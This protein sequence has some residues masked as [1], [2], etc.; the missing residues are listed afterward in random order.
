MDRFV[1]SNSTDSSVVVTHSP[2]RRNTFNQK[3]IPSFQDF[4]QYAQIR[5]L[6]RNFLRLVH[7]LPQRAEMMRQIRSQFREP[8]EE[9]WHR[10]RAV[11]DGTKRFK[12]LSTMVGSSVQVNNKEVDKVDEDAGIAKNIPTLTWPWQR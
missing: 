3:H 4:Q 12:E 9:E 7:P 1:S 8:L 2:R 5:Q 10:K 6:Y 11:A